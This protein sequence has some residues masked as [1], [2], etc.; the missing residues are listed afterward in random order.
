MGK[1]TYHEQVVIPKLLS[2]VGLQATIDEA[3]VT[4]ALGSE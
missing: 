2:L 1:G 3:G 4:P